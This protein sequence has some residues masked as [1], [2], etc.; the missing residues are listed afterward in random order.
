M[1]KHAVEFGVETIPTPWPQPARP[2][3]PIVALQKQL[4]GKFPVLM[5]PVGGFKDEVQG[6]HGSLAV[7][8]LYISRDAAVAKTLLQPPQHQGFKCDSYLVS[9][10]P[11]K[12][13]KQP[14]WV[15]SQQRA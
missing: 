9:T 14:G 2:S 3:E 12:Q 15:P 1:S 5:G 8:D 10:G 6:P 7:L 13:S 4:V 11:R